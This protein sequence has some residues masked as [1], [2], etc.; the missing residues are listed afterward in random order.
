[1]KKSEETASESSGC[2][3]CFTCVKKSGGKCRA[4]AYESPKADKPDFLTALWEKDPAKYYFI[5]GKQ[6]EADLKFDKAANEFANA[7][8][9]AHANKSSLAL[10]YKWAAIKAVEMAEVYDKLK[11]MMD[12][13]LG[14][15]KRV[16][17]TGIW[18]HF[19]Y[20]YLAVP[21]EILDA[22]KR[23]L[24][25]DFVH[26]VMRYDIK[27][28]SITFYHIPD[29]ISSNEPEIGHAYSVF[30][31]GRVVHIPKKEDPDLLHHKWMLVSP[32]DKLFNL[33]DLTRRSVNIGWLAA[34]CDD[35]IYDKPKSY[36]LSRVIPY[37]GRRH[38]R[39]EAKAA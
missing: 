29:F 8:E 12:P 13:Y 14:F 39:G 10:E 27:E 24:P 34:G 33:K 36:W 18:I 5:I 22:R 35:N 32:G 31:D 28:D 25:A 4:A 11:G 17:G 16:G 20:E 2:I 38:N 37:I 30:G 1:M 21:P 15:G 19:N 23:K 26:N 6:F 7:F 3:D 9:V